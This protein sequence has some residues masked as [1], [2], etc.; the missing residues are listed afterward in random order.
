MLKSHFLIGCL[1]IAAFS[2]LV[3]ATA[4]E[5]ALPGSEQQLDSSIFGG[6]S[7]EVTGFRSARF[8]M[9][10][11]EVRASIARDFNVLDKDLTVSENPIER[12]KVFSLF[13]Q[14]LVPR[15]GRAQVTYVMGFQWR[16]LIQVSITWSSASDA[17]MTPQILTANSEVLQAHLRRGGYRSETVATDVPL[18]T[19][20]LVVFR[21]ADRKGHMTQLTITGTTEEDRNGNRL[22]T[23]KQL[24]LFYV[25][26]PARPDIFRL[27]PGLF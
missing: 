4:T 25:A 22:L 24:Q 12:T 14:D 19:N 9:T 11:A 26:D 20:G 13:V 21:G 8:G 27:K 5:A 18:G 2:G 16:R 10:E 1:L 15:G 7:A 6:G 3:V 17:R 23:P